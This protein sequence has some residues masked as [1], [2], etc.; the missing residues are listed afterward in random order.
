ME[1]CGLCGLDCVCQNNRTQCMRTLSF[2]LAIEM[3]KAFCEHFGFYF[4]NFRDIY[5]TFTSNPKYNTS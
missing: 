2:I 5:V 4:E 1:L 3:E